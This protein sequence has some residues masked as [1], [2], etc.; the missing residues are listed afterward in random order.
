MITII[1]NA[2]RNRAVISSEDYIINM[3]KLTAWDNTG[4]YP[5]NKRHN[6]ITPID[7]IEDTKENVAKLRDLY[8]IIEEASRGETR[9]LVGEISE[10]NFKEEDAK[11]CY[12]F[13]KTMI[14]H[15][16]KEG[17]KYGV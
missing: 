14:D 1:K 2:E 9:I 3:K 12:S 4:Y 5:K 10:P 11:F 16:N 6:I 7:K 8:D 17:I 15:V 13:V